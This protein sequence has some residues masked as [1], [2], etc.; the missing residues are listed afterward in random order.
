MVAAHTSTE[1]GP[2]VEANNTASRR[3]NL[4]ENKRKQHACHANMQFGIATGWT[5]SSIP[6]APGSLKYL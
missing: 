1:D 4:K 2:E 3:Q 6:H 5:V